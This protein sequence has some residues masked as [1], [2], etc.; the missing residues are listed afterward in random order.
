M[1]AL[2]CLLLLFLLSGC[3]KLAIGV[4]WADTFAAREAGKFFDLD[5]AAKEKARAEFRTAFLEVRR[6]EFPLVA[7][8]LEGVAGEVEKNA[9]TAA[10]LEHWNGEV[11]SIVTAAAKRFEPLG[12]RLVAEQA[13]RGFERFDERFL[14]GD[15]DSRDRLATPEARLQHAWK[16]TDR[17]IGETLGSLSPEQK[18]KLEP[19][20]ATL[21]L[22]LERESSRAVF[23]QFRAA[24]ALAE[25]R[26]VFLRRYF[27]EWDSLQK[28]EYVQARNAYVKRSFPVMAELLSLA[29][30]KQKSHLVR[31][32]RARAEEL[33]KLSHVH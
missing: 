1:R 20:L 16:R 30:E 33:R 15:A 5:S 27:F 26:V 2:P 14:S 23:D 32:F 19:L 17:V 21:P 8:V 6:Q 7:A 9:L 10:R 3:S 18:G 24:R 31:N 28:P 11:R 4:Y 25:L 13:A 29:T 22:P 12:Q